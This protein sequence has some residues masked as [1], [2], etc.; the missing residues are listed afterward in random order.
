MCAA[1]AHMCIP[2]AQ[3]R[4]KLLQDAGPMGKLANPGVQLL[5]KVSAAE[6]AM[7]TVQDAIKKSVADGSLLSAYNAQTGATLLEALPNLG[8]N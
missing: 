7:P 8:R 6:S 2:P 5:I 4:R 3:A 1:L